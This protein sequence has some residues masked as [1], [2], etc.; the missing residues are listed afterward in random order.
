[1]QDT[2]RTVP[3]PV[4]AGKS[5]QQ[6][7]FAI[8]AAYGCEEIHIKTDPATQL[9]AIIAIHNTKLGPAVGGC[10]CRSYPSATAA[11]VDALRLARGMSYKA[12]LAGVARGG[13]KA[14]LVCP[15]RIHN[16]EALFE[17][18]GDFIESLGGRYATA[19]DNGTS[20]ADMD[21]I[22][23]RTRHVLSLSKG[24][25]GTG[26]PSP[27]TARGIRMAIEVAVG[28]VLKRDSLEDIHVA[29]QGVGH[30]GYALA[31]ELHTRGAQLTV[32]DTHS[33]HMQRCADEFGARCVS[34]ESIY[35]VRCDIFSPCALGAV[36]NDTTIQ[37]FSTR[38][39]AGAANNQL[40]DKRHGQLLYQRGILYLPDYVINAGGLIFV[41]QDNPEKRERQLVAMI[42]T[43][44]E[45][46]TRSMHT[47]TPPFRQADRMAGEIL[48]LEPD[49]RAA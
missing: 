13:G 30:V 14:V 20:T 35:D 3:N 2:G 11:I 24:K 29:I 47:G 49:S 8:A 41:L 26:D 36:V 5:E 7:L 1:M 31:R 40:E 17:S 18:F 46:L 38:I 6:D 9:K 4:P 42:N 23:R 19:V 44:D 27:F 16:R 33:D 22:A 32:T 25:G 12:A 48:G 15:D 34:P 45:L 39:I 21:I 10:R 28:K 43:L 37:R